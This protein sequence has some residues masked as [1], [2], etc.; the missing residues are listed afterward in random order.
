MAGVFLLLVGSAAAGFSVY[1]TSLMPLEDQGYCIVVARLPA[2][3]SQPR[4]RDT[5]SAIDTVLGS[6]KG[7]KGWVTIGGYSAMDMAKVA[8]VVTTFVVFE[9][10]DK[11][12]V[13]FSLVSFLGALNKR[14]EAVPQASFSVLPPSPIPGLGTAFGFQMMIEDRGNLGSHELQVATNALLDQAHDQPG[15]LRV[16]FTTFDANSPQIYLDIDRD[17]ARSLGVAVKDVLSSVQTYLGSSYVNPFNQFNQSFQVR[18]QGD[19]DYRRRIENILGLSLMNASGQMV[20]LG[21]LA[22]AVPVTGS[23]LVYRYN[24]YPAASLV[25][26]PTPKYSSGEALDKMAELSRSALPPGMSYDWTGLAYQEKLMGNQSALVFALSITLVFLILAAQYESWLDPAAVILTV[27][28]ALV[29]IIVAL[30]IRK[31]P[32]DIYTQIGLVLMTA[33]AAKNAILIVEFARELHAE[34]MAAAEA[35]VEATR[36]RLRPIIMTSLAFILGVVPLLEAEGAGSA[37]QRAL[38]TVVFGGML[39]STLFAIPFVPVFFILMHRIGDRMRSG[40]RIPLHLS[41]KDRRG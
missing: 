8:T 14:F 38:G 16:G 28:M 18:V 34:G 17:L 4:V 7:V 13:G 6:V 24:L 5:A 11:R 37:S 25:G 22:K 35:A 27:P 9:D 31:F 29:G 33:L 12:P 41:L 20:P 23:E 39:A 3:S 21:T 1:P 36:R 15:L 30:I 32:I 26:I 40:G 2:G 19:A 10:W